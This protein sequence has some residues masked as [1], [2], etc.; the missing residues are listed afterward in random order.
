M[1]TSVNAKDFTI[2][3]PNTYMST[4]YINITLNIVVFAEKMVNIAK[5]FD[6]NLGQINK[7]YVPE[8]NVAGKLAFSLKVLLAYAKNRS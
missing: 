3:S 5:S 4:K 1:C 6:H 7:K 2:F 8:Q